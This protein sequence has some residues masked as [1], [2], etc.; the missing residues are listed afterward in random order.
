MFNLKEFRSKPDRLSDFLPWAALVAPGVILNKDGSF[1]KT[2]RFRGPDL[3]SA[4]RGELITITAQINN[5]L[6]RLS[7]GWAIYAEAQRVT[8]QKY[9][10]SKFPDLITAMIDEERKGF[11]A[12][13]NHYENNY[14]FTLFYLPPQ[15]TNNRF[16]KFIIERDMERERQAYSAHL[17]TFLTEVDRIYTLFRELMAEAEPL[18]DEETLT[19]LH[20]CIS[21]GRHRVKVPEIPMYLDAILADTPL[22]GGLEPRLGN[23]HLRVIT[24]MGF[25]GTTIP[26]ILDQL[27]RLNFEYRWVTRFLPLDKIDAL[28]EINRYRKQWF[29]KRKGVMTLIRETV[30]QTESAMVDS[31]A[32]NKSLDSDAAAQEL[33]DDAVSYGYFTA[34]VVV[35][36]PDANIVEK[37]VRAV[38]KSINSLGFNVVN[39]T[40]NAVDAW[41]G[42]LPGLCRANVRRPLF[43]S[44]NLAHVFPLSAI[45]AGPK[46]NKHLNGPV[47]MHVQTPDATPFRLSLHVGDVGHTMIVGPT[48]AGKSVLLSTLASQFRRYPDAQ[49]YFFDKGG[50]CRALT[51]GVGGDFYDL[52]DESEGTL[53]FQPL[54]A[55]DEENERSWAAEWVYD[56]LRGEN[57]EITPD[58]KKLVWTALSS[59]AT[60]PRDQR[61]ITGLT[62]LLQDNTLRQALEPFT[63]NGAFGKLFDATEDNL[64]YGSWQWCEMEKLMNTPA[65]V[66]PTL[67]Y[68]FHKLEQRFTG[69]PTMLVLDECWLFLD[70]PVFAAKIREWLKVLRKANVSVVFATQSLRDVEASPIAPAISESCLTKIYLPN[71]NARDEQTS[72]TYYNFG[73]NSREIEIISM[74]TAKRQYYYKSVYGSRLFELALGPVALAYC[75]AS[76]KED[77]RM[78]RQLL[79]EVGRERFNEE[80]LK[81]KKLTHEANVYREL[82][83]SLARGEGE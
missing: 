40:L 37:K 21:L 17:K 23:H 64:D 27:N 43:S 44:L 22:I 60:S 83:E 45:W 12:S 2:F 16:E 57:I 81:Y 31:D 78:V 72:K 67:S 26:G 9:P 65:A 24:V 11:F 52:A 74:A 6:K 58:I 79:A 18:D 82:Q 77:Q 46:L 33:G 1:Q 76:S 7:G 51:A 29:A 10:D 55:I 41:F 5:I 61:T 32:L 8:S 30:S 80:W 39:E 62:L 56:L 73:L 13:G 42:S 68:L 48:G 38:E 47:L 66:P 14:Y 35:S 50:S 28:A 15:E 4:T 69:K 19:Y 34:V 59:L 25:P 71:S 3:D 70:N 53:S 54:A 75:A 63:L 36:D 20:S 49:V